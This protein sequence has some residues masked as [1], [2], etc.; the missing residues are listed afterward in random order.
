MKYCFVL[1]VIVCLPALTS[2]QS[3]YKYLGNGMTV[4][5]SLSPNLGIPFNDRGFQYV[6]NK[7]LD[8]SEQHLI[9]LDA[10]QS[11]IKKLMNFPQQDYGEWVESSYRSALSQFSEC[12]G[13]IAAAA[14]T[15]NPASVFVSF[16]PAPFTDPSLPLPSGELL[17]G[18]FIPEALEIRAVAFYKSETDGELAYLPSVMTWEWGNAIANHIGIPGE[19]RGANWP[20]Q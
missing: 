7:R 6:S 15:F 14:A 17:A 8:K 1:L 4:P 5:D 12:G 20:C 18:E 11:Q 19:P 13:P 2:A 9:S 10:P 3:L 16:E